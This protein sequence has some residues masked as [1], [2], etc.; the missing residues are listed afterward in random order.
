MEIREAL[1]TLLV[2]SAYAMSDMKLND[3]TKIA[4]SHQYVI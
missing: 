4:V 1:V 2:L 3:N